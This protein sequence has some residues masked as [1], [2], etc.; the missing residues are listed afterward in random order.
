MKR[1]VLTIMLALTAMFS[2]QM[3]VCAAAP[4]ASEN[5][6]SKTAAGNQNCV[7]TTENNDVASYTIIVPKKIVLDSNGN[8]KY[9]VKFQGDIDGARSVKVTVP[10]SFTMS[11]TGKADISINNWFA[12]TAENA[13][14]ANADTYTD[15][16]AGL[17]YA[18]WKVGYTGT[19]T[20][21][22]MAS[23]DETTIAYGKLAPA[24]GNKP[25]A[26]VWSGTFDFTI[27]YTAAT[28]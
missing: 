19:P 3:N 16:A 8:A 7:V 22:L 17:Q 25:S 21:H 11:Q 13:T 5:E 23:N 9:Q 28:P 10:E 4:V 14:G 6:A 2:L 24:S 12:T 26:G 18:E 15:K 20:N 27:V 1:K